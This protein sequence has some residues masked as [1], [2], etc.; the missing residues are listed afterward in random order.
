M[1]YKRLFL[2]GLEYKSRMH[3]YIPKW[4]VLYFF[5]K[6]PFCV[7]E[8]KRY[9]VPAHL[10]NFIFSS[11]S[12]ILPACLSLPQQPALERIGGVHL[13]CGKRFEAFVALT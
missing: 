3:S 4:V 6:H 13:C 5:N 1:I 11:L 12:H 7:S 10:H 2:P 9:T 8:I